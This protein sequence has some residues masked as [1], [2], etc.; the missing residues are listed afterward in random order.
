MARM[1]SELPN[2]L[3]K[4]FE[5]LGTNTGKM[6][7]EMTKAGAEFVKGEVEKRTKRVFKN[8]TEILKGLKIT[9]VYKTKSDDGVNTKVAFYGYMPTKDRNKFKLTKK[10]K[11]GKKATYEYEGIP[12]PL[13]VAAREYGTKSGE[14]KKPFIRPSFN[15]S[16]IR[17]IMEEVQKRYLPKE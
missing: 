6:M 15:K 17:K 13:V 10:L 7:G 11:N 5:Q 12:I 16:K 4:E 14:Q 2:D 1:E 9:K 3:I 8:S